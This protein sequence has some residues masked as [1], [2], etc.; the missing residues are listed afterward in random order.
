MKAMKNQQ[1]FAQSLMYYWGLGGKP[2]AY[3]L[4]KNEPYY[5]GCNASADNYQFGYSI[6]EMLVA[7]DAGKI[8]VMSGGKDYGVFFVD[9]YKGIMDGIAAAKA[10]GKDIE[11]VYEVPGWP[12]PKSL[13]PIRPLHWQPTPMAWPAH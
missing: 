6:A 4:V 7:N 8:I 10:D 1:N 5:I 13:P 12:E 9:R 3:E 2:E 11:V